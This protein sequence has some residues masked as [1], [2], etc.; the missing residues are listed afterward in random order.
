MPNIIEIYTSFSVLIMFT[1][2]N[3]KDS[4]IYNYGLIKMKF[5]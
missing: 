4:N 5:N 3:D 1:K 2:E